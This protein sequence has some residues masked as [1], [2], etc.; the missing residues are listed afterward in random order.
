M[1]P[2]NPFDRLHHDACIAQIDA[3]VAIEIV[4]LPV[5]V[6]VDKNIGRV[7]VLMPRVRSPATLGSHPARVVLR[8]AEPRH[9][10]EARYANPSRLQ[11][12]N[13]ELEFVHQRLVQHHVLWPNVLLIVREK[14]AQAKVLGERSILI[15]GRDFDEAVRTLVR[16]QSSSE[17]TG[18]ETEAIAADNAASPGLKGKQRDEGKWTPGNAV[19]CGIDAGSPLDRIAEESLKN[20]NVSTAGRRKDTCPELPAPAGERVV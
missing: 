11:V 4:H 12:G 6:I 1:L 13:E 9:H 8:R 14:I 5:E 17:F 2:L 18:P 10:T 3:S 16:G 19:G 15:R 20:P 7:T